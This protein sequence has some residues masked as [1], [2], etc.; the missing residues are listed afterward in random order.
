[1]RLDTEKISGKYFQVMMMRPVVREKVKALAGG[2][3]KSM[4]NI[5]KSRLRD[6]CIAVPSLEEQ[7]AFE[8]FL[9]QLEG[10][11]RKIVEAGSKAQELFLSLQSR[12]FRGEL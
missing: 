8:R 6:L 7:Y 2:S 5:S 11:K 1:M 9:D 10:V 12:A 3:A 4:S